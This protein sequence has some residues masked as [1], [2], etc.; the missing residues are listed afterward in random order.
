MAYEREVLILGIGNILW[1]DE[2]FGVRAVEALNQSHEFPAGVEIMDGGTL[3]M[4]LLDAVCTSRSILIF[5]C[6]D[7]KAPPTTLR[8]LR[9]DEIRAWSATKLSPHQ[10]GFNDVLAA[11]AL[12]G[13]YP[14]RITV[15]GVQPLLLD[16][17]GG[18]LSPELRS[19]LPKAVALGLAELA[20]W[21][22]PGTPR[23]TDRPA[24][25]LNTSAMDLDNYE[26]G[27]PPPE[28]ACRTGDDRFPAPSAIAPR[29]A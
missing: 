20:D 8:V 23:P 17:Y 21:G 7:L 13:H 25:R 4:Y 24:P 27:R 29:E 26:L 10:T 11:A 19:L 22:W 16:D 14:E 12:R 2:G 5:D 1:A 6:A 9:D 3:G 15:V 18:T 28:A